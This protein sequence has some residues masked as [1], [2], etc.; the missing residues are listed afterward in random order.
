MYQNPF[1]AG[2]E[3]L[4]RTSGYSIESHGD[5]SAT[6]SYLINNDAPDYAVR[7]Y[8]PTEHEVFSSLKYK[9]EN[10]GYDSGLREIQESL[11]GIPLE[12]YMPQTLSVDDGVGKSTSIKLENP[13]KDI[14]EKIN[15]GIIN[16]ILRAQEEVK[17]QIV[18]RDI[19]IED[20]LV[21]RRTIRKREIVFK[22]KDI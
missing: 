10:I 17:S 5:L 18:F 8:H 6:A 4:R 7:F 1:S 14:S 3:V 9:Q 2:Y 16:E 11:Q 19:Q 21:L 13:F 22:E 15:K 20:T 12:F